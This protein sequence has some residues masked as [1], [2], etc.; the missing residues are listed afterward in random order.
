M[1]IR[2]PHLFLFYFRNF[3]L[4]CL[5][6]DCGLSFDYDYYLSSFYSFGCGGKAAAETIKK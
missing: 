4:K 3:F 2:F 5:N 1:W 6:N